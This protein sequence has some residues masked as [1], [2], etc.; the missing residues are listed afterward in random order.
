MFGSSEN[1]TMNAK[2][3]ELGGGGTASDFPSASGPPRSFFFA[4]V[5]PITSDHKRGSFSEIA[6]IDFFFA[7]RQAENCDRGLLNC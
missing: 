2:G 5:L 3:I 7:H 4:L 1:Q 6:M